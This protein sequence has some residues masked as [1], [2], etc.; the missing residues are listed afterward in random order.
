MLVCIYHPEAGTWKCGSTH[1]PQARAGRVMEGM[2][3]LI[4]FKEYVSFNFSGEM[5]RNMRPF[6]I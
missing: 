3:H 1:A 4:L 2:Q 5:Q 6:G